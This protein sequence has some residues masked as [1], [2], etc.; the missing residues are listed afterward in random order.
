[1]RCSVPVVGWKFLCLLV[2][3]LTPARLQGQV[4]SAQARQLR[5]QV[6]ELQRRLDQLRRQEGRDQNVTEIGSSRGRSR[7][8][9]EPRLVARIYDLSD[10]FSI[11]PSYPAIEPAD[12][13]DA[14]RAIFLSAGLNSGDS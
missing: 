3:G 11:A 4:E 2:L 13:Q 14:P 7:V 12:L 10:L 6:E 9:D 5:G 8:D 1:M